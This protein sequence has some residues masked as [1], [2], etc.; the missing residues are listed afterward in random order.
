MKKE[1]IACR[2]IEFWYIIE[3][4]NQDIFPSETKDNKKNESNNY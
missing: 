4:L 1:E 2:I 3:F